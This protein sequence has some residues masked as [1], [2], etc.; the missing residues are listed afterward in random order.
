MNLSRMS[1]N[2]ILAVAE[3]IM[4]NLMEGSE[5]IDHEKHTQDFTPRLKS[6]VTKQNLENQCKIYQAAWG[7]FAERAFVDIFRK[8]DS[9][10]VIWKQKVTKVDDEFVALLTLVER[11]G[12]Y[13]VD[14]A[15]L[16]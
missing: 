1:D 12:R 7:C 10:T 9:V 11:E 5:R 15:I 13:L 6:I 2:E 4:R 14:N 3:P 16:Y 8:K